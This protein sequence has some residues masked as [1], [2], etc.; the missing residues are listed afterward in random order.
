MYKTTFTTRVKSDLEPKMRQLMGDRSAEAFFADMVESQYDRHLNKNV[1]A[2]FRPDLDRFRSSVGMLEDVLVDVMRQAD[3]YLLKAREETSIQAEG[4]AQEV[5]KLEERI[6]DLSARIA[7]LETELAE[8]R[9]RVETQDKEVGQVKQEWTDKE[10][11]WR[12]RENLLQGRISRM[13]DDVQG[14]LRRQRELADQIAELKTLLEDAKRAIEAGE[15]RMDAQSQSHAAEMKAK[16]LEAERRVLHAEKAAKDSLTV[17]YEAQIKDLTA[18]IDLARKE[19]REIAQRAAANSEKKVLSLSSQAEASRAALKAEIMAVT[20][21]IEDLHKEYG[22]K[23]EKARSDER[24]KATIREEEIRSALDKTLL[25]LQNENKVLKKR[26]DDLKAKIEEMQ[27]EHQRDLD[28]MTRRIEQARHEE[29]AHAR[30]TADTLKQRVQEMEKGMDK[31][32]ETILAM[33]KE[34]AQEGGA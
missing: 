8:S 14:G 25:D 3:K 7:R 34:K 19:E 33:K 21:Q 15:R 28:G 24:D 22:L 6:R 23:I 20:A 5:A 2:L 16:E 26:S 31:A 13:E 9:T 18:K 4:H 27:R 29:R 1:P 17:K 12:E 32:Q 10:K 11:A 30:K